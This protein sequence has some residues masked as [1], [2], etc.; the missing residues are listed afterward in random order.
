MNHCPV[1]ENADASTRSA[2]KFPLTVAVEV[3]EY[4]FAIFSSAI[5]AE[6]I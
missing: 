1:K 6:R 2:V 5:K 3:E 4:E